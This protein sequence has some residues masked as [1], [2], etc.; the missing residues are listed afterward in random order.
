MNYQFSVKATEAHDDELAQFEADSLEEAVKMFAE[1]FPE[2]IRNIECITREIDTG[3]VYEAHN[4][5]EA[6][7]L[8]NKIIKQ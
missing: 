1:S 7:E 5:D 4:E 2:D 3:G 8:I 6:K